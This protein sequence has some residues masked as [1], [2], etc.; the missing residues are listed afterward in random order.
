MISKCQL[1]IFILFVLVNSALSA[2]RFAIP[3]FPEKD[4][5]LEDKDFNING[6]SVK[7]SMSRP[8]IIFKK[9]FFKFSFFE[10]NKPITIKNP[11]IKFNMKMDMGKY[12]FK[13]KCNKNICTTEIILPKCIWGDDRWF[14][15]LTFQY[16]SKNYKIIFFFN[17]KD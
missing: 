11:F 5:T 15:K 6:V 12:H 7:I 4:I 10:S 17:I 16:K 3:Y 1:L 14:G 13:P 8:P 9:I 2:E